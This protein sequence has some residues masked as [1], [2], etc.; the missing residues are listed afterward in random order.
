MS[1]RYKNSEEFFRRAIKNIPLGS[2]TFSKSIYAYP[3]GASPLFV[4]SAYGSKVVDID[5]NEYIDLVN[6]LLSVLLGHNDED[7]FN[8]VLKQMRKGTNFSLPHPLEYEVSELIISTVKSVEMVRYGK[9]GS[10][11]TSAAIRIARAYTGQDHVAVCGYHGWHDWYIGS[12]ARNLGVPK[13][14][15]EL[16]HTFEYN[17]ISSL[18]KIFDDYKGKVAC[19]ILEPMNFEWPKDNFLEDVQAIARDNNA[20]LVFDEN[21]TGFRYSIGGAQELFNICPDLTIFGKGIGNGFPLSVI[22]GAKEFMSLAEEIFFSG[23][24]SGEPIALAAA[25]TVINKIVNNNVLPHIHEVG[26]SL[27]DAIENMI[28]QEQLDE[29]VNIG[30]HPSWTM[31]RFSNFSK[32]SSFEIKTLFLQE[33]FKRG[34]LTTGSN[35]IS[36]AISKDEDLTTIITSYSEVL[37]IVSDA[38]RKNKVRNLLECDP[39][40]PL[41]Q[42]R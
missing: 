29:V 27:K 38:I 42:I 41:F 19:V 15:Q 28:K 16:T 4:E 2:Q 13:A 37:N 7:V 8:S 14:V 5:G 24:F 10:D 23:T 36:Y 1:D 11:A 9:N 12:T 25:K 22:G 18:E 30:G 33:M 32:Y 39:I 34:I 21:I 3:Y 20:L 17:N 26:T 35:N 40:K 6:A 31:L